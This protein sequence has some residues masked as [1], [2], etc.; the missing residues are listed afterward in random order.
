MCR[1]FIFRGGFGTKPPQ[2]ARYVC[3]GHI[4]IDGGEVVLISFMVLLRYS[5]GGT[6]LYVSTTCPRLDHFSTKKYI[7]FKMP[8]FYET[9]ACFF[10]KFFRADGV[11]VICGGYAF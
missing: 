2:N 3:K 8:T 4:R 11:R 9:R 1:D 7:P 5:F 10:C 6:N